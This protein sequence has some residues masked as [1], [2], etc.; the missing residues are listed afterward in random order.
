MP[1][2]VLGNRNETGRSW[3]TARQ[4]GA[5]RKVEVLSPTFSLFL[6]LVSGLE[7]H[8]AP[9]LSR[10]MMGGSQCG[11]RLPAP[12]S[13]MPP[14]HPAGH[15]AVT[16]IDAG[17]EQDGPAAWSGRRGPHRPRAAT[18]HSEQQ[19]LRASRVTR[20]PLPPPGPRL[21]VLR[22]QRQGQHQRGGGGAATGSVRNAGCR[23]TRPQDLSPCYRIRLTP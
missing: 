3:A 13:P 17:G 18:G 10:A 22:E 8:L 9:R 4:G 6:V 20:A 1:Q 15:Q 21:P 7:L 14:F 23:G 2:P 16:A 11:C 5:P 19:L 12:K